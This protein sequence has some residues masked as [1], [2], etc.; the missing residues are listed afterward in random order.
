MKIGIVG[1][2][3][4]GS[5]LA[6]RLS[7][8]HKIVGYEKFEEDKF[9]SICGWATS[10]YAMHEIAKKCGLNFDDY[11]LYEGDT[12][13]LDLGRIKFE[14]KLKGLCI[15]D[16]LSFIKDMRENIDVNFGKYITRDSLNEMYEL[17]IDAT[18]VIRSLLPKI[19]DDLLIPCVQ[20]KVK[21][22]D[23]PYDDFYVKPFTGASGYLWYF[24]LGNGY[25]HLGAGDYYKRHEVELKAFLNRHP[26][27]VLKKVGRP[28]RVTPPSFCE[29]FYQGN[30]VGVG[31]AIGT[32]Y[33]M[34]GEGIIP[35][36]QCA[37]LLIDNLHDLSKY[38]KEVLRKFKIFNIVYSLIKSKLERRFSLNLKLLPILRVFLHMKRNEKRYG[39][40]VKISYITDVLRI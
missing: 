1:M 19:K 9:D 14:M 5:Y 40:G 37:D 31:E 17:I 36:L 35:S 28:I 7:N 4:A 30:V 29:P 38:R 23:P 22:K 8:E 10:K 6:S 16:K 26:G 13:L 3:V 25:V 27:E 12:M 34:L 32:V 2:G 24:P 11:I 15:F 20:Y 33:P 39:V 18:G 21:F